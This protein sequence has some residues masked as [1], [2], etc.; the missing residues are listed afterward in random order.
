MF[1]SNFYPVLDPIDRFPV[2]Q[3]QTAF[4]HKQVIAKSY[5]NMALAAV[6]YS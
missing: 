4:D 1:V 3:S 6:S 5:I 2:G